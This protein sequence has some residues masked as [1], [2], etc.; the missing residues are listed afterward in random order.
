[1]IAMPMSFTYQLKS[2]SAS[3][4]PFFRS[5]PVQT[6]IE[7]LATS[8]DLRHLLIVGVL[9][10]FQEQKICRLRAPGPLVSP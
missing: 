7:T 1:M 10:S 8:L 9:Y 3:R 6:G 4:Q 2:W 5:L